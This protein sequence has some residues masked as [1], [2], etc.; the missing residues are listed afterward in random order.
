MSAGYMYGLEKEKYL[1]RDRSEVGNYK[2]IR[3]LEFVVKMLCWKEK[4]E[5]RCGEKDIKVDPKND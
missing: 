5:S 2:N 1:D 3:G 4:P